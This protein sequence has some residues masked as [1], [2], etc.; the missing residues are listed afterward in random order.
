MQGHPFTLVVITR[1]V[2]F[3]GEAGC[4]EGLLAAGVEKLHLRKPGA[5]EDALEALLKQLNPCWYPR[6]VLHGGRE[7]QGLAARYVIPQVHCPLREL[8]SEGP[9]GIRHRYPLLSAS[10][11][12][13][14]ELKKMEVA[15]LSYV[16]MSPVFNSISKPGYTANPSLLQRPAGPYPCKVIG[17]GGVDRDTI[18][19]LV[20]GGWDGAAVLGWIWEQPGAV[21]ERYEQLKNSIS[22]NC[23]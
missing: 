22:M 21:V 23:L 12:S 16:F 13:W 17:L 11:H 5:G 18:G 7:L 19:E 8:D 6:L 1:P 3:P 20:R 4:L 9:L 2:F 15:G 10:L 14:E